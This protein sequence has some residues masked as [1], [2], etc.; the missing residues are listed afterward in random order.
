MEGL[1][2]APEG[3]CSIRAGWPCRL[4]ALSRSQHTRRWR[5]PHP[6]AP[7]PSTLVSPG[8]CLPGWANGRG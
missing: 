8:S 2:L 1:G 7:A 4:V 6:E 5:P 3:L